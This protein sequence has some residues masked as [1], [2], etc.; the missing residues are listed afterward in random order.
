M[1]ALIAA[2]RSVV[3]WSRDAMRTRTCCA[4]AV[5]A[6]WPAEASASSSGQNGVG[7]AACV[8][9]VGLANATVGAG[10]HPC[11]L[12]TTAYPAS[13]AVSS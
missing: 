6:A 4:G 9:R 2:V 8:E 1:S 13:A 7:D 12:P 3:M 10:V 5:V 11:Q